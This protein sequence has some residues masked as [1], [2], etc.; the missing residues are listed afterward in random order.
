M[1]MWWIINR[2]TAPA[3]MF[4]E[5]LQVPVDTRS[6]VDS[7]QPLIWGFSLLVGLRVTF[8]LHR[9]IVDRLNDAL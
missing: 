8:W 5:M 1:A 3:E 4:G 9:I 7:A 2:I 6:I